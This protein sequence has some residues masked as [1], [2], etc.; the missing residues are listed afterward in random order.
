MSVLLI[1]IPRGASGLYRDGVNLYAKES[2]AA[3]VEKE[4]IYAGWSALDCL[5]TGSLTELKAAYPV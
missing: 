3:K 2:K 5:P 1:L 4:Q